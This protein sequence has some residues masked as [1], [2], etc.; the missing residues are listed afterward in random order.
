M[1]KQNTN[2]NYQWRFL[3]K[4]VEGCTCQWFKFFLQFTSSYIIKNYFLMQVIKHRVIRSVKRVQ[5]TF[6][7]GIITCNNYYAIDSHF[8]K[9][10]ILKPITDSEI[11]G[12]KLFGSKNEKQF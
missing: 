3:E 4:H 1:A 6:H 9:S 5:N 8:I 7:A 2:V 11:Q 12:T 10:S